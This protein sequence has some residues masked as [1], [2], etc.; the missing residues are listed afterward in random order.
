MKVASDSASPTCLNYR[1]RVLLYARNPNWDLLATVTPGWG[2]VALDNA[3]SNERYHSALQCQFRTVRASAIVNVQLPRDA[4]CL[5]SREGGVQRTEAV[6]VQVN[7][8]Q[9]IGQG[10]V[11]YAALVAAKKCFRPATPSTVGV[12]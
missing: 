6:D 8:H 12:A 2:S 10:Q 4:A 7:D 5:V 9:A 11:G 1:V 3:S